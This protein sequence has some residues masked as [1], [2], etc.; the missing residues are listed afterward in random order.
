MFSPCRPPRERSALAVHSW[1]A[2]GAERDAAGADDLGDE[3]PGRADPA[4]PAQPESTTI[5]TRAAAVAS[6]DFSA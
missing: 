4:A 2:E 6:R 3:D 1:S 5:P